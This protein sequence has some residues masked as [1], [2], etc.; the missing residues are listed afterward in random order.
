MALFAL[1][2]MQRYYATTHL[3]STWSFCF[4]R[5]QPPACQSLHTLPDCRQYLPQLSD[6]EMICFLF[7]FQWWL[8]NVLCGVLFG[9]TQADQAEMHRYES[10]NCKENIPNITWYMSSASSDALY[11]NSRRSRSIRV[12]LTARNDVVIEGNCSIVN[13]DL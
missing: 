2:D 4:A 9:L 10:A 3:H 7:S 6:L 11:E 1:A 5:E 12:T 8:L 13:N